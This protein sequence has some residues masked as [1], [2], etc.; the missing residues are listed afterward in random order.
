MNDRRSVLVVGA[1]G[2]LGARIVDF[3][4]ARHQQTRALVRRTSNVQSLVELEVE[5]VYGSLDDA[6]SLDKACAGIE[7]VIAT[8]SSIIPGKGD[9]FGERDVAWYENLVKACKRNKVK[10]LVY[11]SAFSTPNQDQVPEFLIKRKIEQI[12]VDSGLSYAIFRSA[13][14]MDVYFAVMGSKIPL[15][16]VTHPTLRRP[17]WLIRLF[18]RLAGRLV[19]AH[20]I[21]LVPGNGAARH[22]FISV[23]NVAEFL[24]CAADGRTGNRL[25]CDIGGPEAVSWDEVAKCYQDILGRPVRPVHLP[26]SLLRFINWLLGRISPAGGNLLAILRLIGSED[27]IC[28][29]SEIAGR[30]GLELRSAKQFLA[31]RAVRYAQAH[32]SPLDRELG[33]DRSARR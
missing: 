29:S 21:A 1:T 17:F 20:G 30:C 10:Q 31:A 27:Y 32:K 4:V 7:A 13:A 3:L 26:V 8:A 14:F 2:Q 12:I 33:D 24:V 23:D 5:L 18:R 11:I 25:I 9:R 19:E 22:A 15:A 28:D 16:G 6:Q